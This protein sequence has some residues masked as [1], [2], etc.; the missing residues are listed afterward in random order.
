MLVTIIEY[1]KIYGKNYDAAR[2][3]AYRGR[4]KTAKKI[5]RDWLIDSEEPYPD[6]RVSS[7]KYIGWRK[8]KKD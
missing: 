5:G 2:R 1:A 4:F 6:E 7:G 8:Q 3:M